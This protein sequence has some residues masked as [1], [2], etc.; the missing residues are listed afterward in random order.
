M[1]RFGAVFIGD[2]GKEEQAM[3]IVSIMAHQDDEMRCLGAMLKC[4][5][6]G[7][8]LFFITLTDGSK[9]FVQQ[10]DLPREQAAAIRHAEMTALAQA[11]GAEFLNLGEPDEFLYDTP[12]TRMKLIEAIRKTRADVIFTH[13]HEDYNLDHITV[14]SLVSHCAM[15]SGLPVLP[16]A[17][18]PLK[19]M[20][21]IFMVE[22]HGP[23]LF[24][25]ACYVDI[26]DYFERKVELLHSHRSQEDAFRAAFQQDLRELCE[27]LDRY[28]GSLVGCRYAEGFIPMAT[29]GA[30]KP[31]PVLP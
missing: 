1:R 24:P 10:P 27:P 14:N 5:A 18:A 6:R 31:Y 21:A 11:L 29:R 23:A 2:S 16:T 8:A 3:N 28:R 12:D 26:T 17:S 25:A 20:P 15:Q 30:I 22:P 4:Q 9:G 13:Y 7:D 19:Q